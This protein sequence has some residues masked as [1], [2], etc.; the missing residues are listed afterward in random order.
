MTIRITTIPA[1]FRSG[2]ASI[3]KLPPDAFET[4][5]GALEKA[6]VV[7][8]L[9]ELTSEVVKQTP[10]FQK[11]EIEDIL[12]AVFSL[13]V[14]MTD[15]DTPLL[16]SLSSLT[17]AMQTSGNA[18]LTLSEQQKTEVEKRLERLLRIKGVVIASK[19]QRLRL[20]YPITFHDAIVLTDIRPVFD[21]PEEQPIGCAI[22]HTLRIAFHENGEHKEFFVALDDAD[23]QTLKKAVQR[24]EAKATGVKALLR[25]TNLPDLS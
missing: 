6:P 8:G 21:K 4:I 16:E 24:A 25:A 23:L 9:K 1:P 11:Q 5:A 2:L 14:L 7:G 20:E 22:S 15:E 10:S 3:K 19:V 12:R 17:R 13:S 18:D